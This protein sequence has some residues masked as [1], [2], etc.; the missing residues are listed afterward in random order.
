MPS[1][2]VAFHVTC[3]F[4]HGLEMRTILAENDEVRFKSYCLEH[5]STTAPGNSNNAMA[6]NS[7]H[8]NSAGASSKPDWAGHGNDHRASVTAP[9]HHQ[10]TSERPPAERPDRDQIE[11]EKASQRKQKLQELEDEFYRLVDP[12]D[13]AESLGLP[14]AHVDFLYQFWKLRRKSNF[15]RPLVT[16]K[17]DEVDNLAQQEQDVLYRR[18][19]LFTHLRQ[20]LE[21]V[22]GWHREGGDS[23]CVCVCVS[24]VVIMTCALVSLSVQLYGFHNPAS[25]I[26]E[27]VKGL[28]L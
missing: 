6:G 1:C 20:D 14:D 18:L 9:D 21:R 2:I 23:V 3:A 13:V 7:N 17:R 11:R 4:D 25:S 28:H 27:M 5:S 16:L 10:A 8:T 15:N 24:F 12:K 26:G 19:K 22:S